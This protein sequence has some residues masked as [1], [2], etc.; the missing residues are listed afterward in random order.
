MRL[1]DAATGA[2][3]PAGRGLDQAE[4]ERSPAAATADRYWIDTDAD[5]PNVGI[6]GRRPRPGE[7]VVAGPNAAGG[8]LALVVANA[9]TTHRFLD[10]ET[11]DV[12][13]HTDRMVRHLTVA[14][15]Y[16]G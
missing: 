5:V 9:L 2:V 14:G 15:H 4:V 13:A 3:D 6:D 8:T 7:P 16:V 11:P 10:P 1:G 12:A